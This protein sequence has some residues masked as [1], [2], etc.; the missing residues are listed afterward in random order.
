MAILLNSRF[1]LDQYS[2][3]DVHDSQINQSMK[4]IG[5]EICT[6]HKSIREVI[7]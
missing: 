7:Y 1:F 3:K 6:S 2:Y 5:R 4:F